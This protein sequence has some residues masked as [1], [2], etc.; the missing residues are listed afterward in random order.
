[1]I[2]AITIPTMIWARTT[3][4]TDRSVG[5]ADRVVG[6]IG[7]VESDMLTLLR[8]RPQRGRA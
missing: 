1:M 2:P 7:S 8:G 3:F 6:A 4:T 5:R